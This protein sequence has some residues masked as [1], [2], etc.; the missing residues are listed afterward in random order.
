MTKDEMG[1]ETKRAKEALRKKQDDND[2]CILS[3]FTEDQA[4]SRTAEDMHAFLADCTDGKAKLTEAKASLE[5]LAKAGKV[6]RLGKLYCNQTY[7]DLPE[8]GHR[9]APIDLWLEKH[10][11]RT[12]A[13]AEFVGGTI[14]YRFSEH[15]VC[16]RSVIVQKLQDP[17]TGKSLGWDAF[18]PAEESNG[19]D[20]T[21]AVLDKYISTKAA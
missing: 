16:G 1:K 21:I 12:I 13:E 17:A 7:L 14:A 10:D 2:A 4:F 15:L 8:N 5:R 3:Y 18:I 9:T 6:H 11:A 20:K 19:V